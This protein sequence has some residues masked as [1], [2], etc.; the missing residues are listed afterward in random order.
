V[1]PVLLELSALLAAAFN[2]AAAVFASLAESAPLEAN[3][4][5]VPLDLLALALAEAD[6]IADAL[7]LALAF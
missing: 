3:E 1:L 4:F 2:V 5:V 6:S 7:L